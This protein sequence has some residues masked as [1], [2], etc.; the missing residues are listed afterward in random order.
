MSIQPM[1]VLRGFVDG[2][3]TLGRWL[4]RALVTTIIAIST[5][6]VIRC[7]L[8][9]ITGSLR[10]MRKFLSSLKLDEDSIVVVASDV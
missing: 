3:R 1:K 5:R 7:G 8:A 2:R 4:Q 10:M 9:C 6:Q